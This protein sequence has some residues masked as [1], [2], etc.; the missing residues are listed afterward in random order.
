M[1]EATGNLTRDAE[2]N[3]AS[4]KSV[5]VNFTIAENRRVFKGGAYVNEP[6][7]IDCA[8]WNR[9]DLAQY[10]TKGTQVQIYGEV[11]AEAYNGK[12][13]LC[14]RKVIDIKFLARPQNAGARQ[15]GNHVNGQ[16]AQNNRGNGQ[17]TNAGQPGNRRPAAPQADDITEPIDDLPF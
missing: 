3:N 6:V 17:R 2:I 9:D 14:V 8:L 1:L 4:N 11:I 16:P 12:A 13:K 15:N 5:A 7:F 10:L